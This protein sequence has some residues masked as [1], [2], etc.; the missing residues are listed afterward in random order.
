[1]WVPVG[2]LGDDSAI[3][4]VRCQ[5]LPKV[6]RLF[7]DFQYICAGA[8]NPFT[9]GSAKSKTD[10]FYKITSWVQLKISAPQLGTAQQ[11]STE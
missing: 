7:L 2:N 11:L 8:F 9:P 1:M 6:Q 10:T 4:V 3:K 5:L